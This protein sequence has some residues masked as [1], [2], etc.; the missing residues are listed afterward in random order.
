M[1]VLIVSP[2]PPDRCGIASYTVQVAATLRKEGHQVDVVSPRPSAARYAANCAR[3][4][5]GV[6]RVLALSRRADRTVVE[7]FPDLLFQEMRRT[8]FVRQWPAVALLF[9]LG[10]R[11]E[12]VVHEAP[13][14]SLVGRTDLRGRIGRAMW[15][16]LLTLPHR[17][18]VH[19]AWERQ[20]LVEATGVRAD[21][22]ALLGHGDSFLRWAGADREQARRELGLS[23]D[24]YLFLSIGFLQ[25]H[26]GF[27]RAIRALARLDGDRVRLHVVGSVRVNSPDVMAHVDLLRHLAAT[28]PGAALHEGYVSDELFDRWII[29]CDALVLPYR[30]IWSSGV[31]ERAKLYGRPAIV[32]DA[33]GLV[34]QADS[35]TRVVR[36]DDELAAA[37]AELSGV[38]LSGPGLR[39]LAVEAEVLTYDSALD[40]IRRRAA[41]LRDH[42]EPG[43]TPPDPLRLGGGATLPPPIVLAAPPPGRGLRTRVKRAVDKL[44]RW[45]LMP[46]AGRI[47]EIRDYLAQQERLREQDGRR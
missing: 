32:S 40:A 2:Y 11:L 27:D 46:L 6:L 29:A 7:F 19:T 1:R 23:P 45:E 20:Q 26:K 34:D 37:M 44:T 22:I 13:Y 8:R 28:V 18:Y 16:T 14:R 24:E 30:D 43:T 3:T 21:R 41:A 31:L 10:R 38:R 5:G 36:D 42:Y 35:A 47:N 17:T 9:A 33:G 25:P 4:A 15:R 12:L 39:S